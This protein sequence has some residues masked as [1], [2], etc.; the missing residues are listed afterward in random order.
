MKRNTLHLFVL[1]LTIVHSYAQSPKVHHA[2]PLHVDLVRDLGARQ[3]EQEI[4]LG[5][6]VSKRS[7]YYV[8]QNFVEYE[9]APIDR[10][11]FEVEIPF[12]LYQ[13]KNTEP[14][15]SS[16][17][18][19]HIE[20][21]KLASQYTFLV[22][23]PLQFSMAVGYMQEF[24]LGSR[25]P[26]IQGY[27]YHP[28]LVVAKRFGKQWHTLFYTGPKWSCDLDQ[29]TE[30]RTIANLSLHYTIPRTSYLIGLECDSEWQTE[31]HAIVLYPQ[32]KL[33]ISQPL[34]L[35]VL[36]GIPLQQSYSRQSFMLR[37]IYE[38]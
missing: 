18:D 5:W 16:I 26:S 31:L 15:P 9:F 10:L 30:T 33:H 32:A 24:E 35:G 27:V 1:L 29:N 23:P 6:E 38:L 12:A 3:G 34:M 2:E 22:S 25:H 7:N 11:A 4:N 37:L 8:H 36:M 17:P 19:N 21:V 20:G 28:F 13:P 14:T